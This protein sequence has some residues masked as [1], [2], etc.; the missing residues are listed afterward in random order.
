MTAATVPRPRVVGVDLARGFALIGMA[1]THMLAVQSPD[2]GRLTLVGWVAAGRASALFAV[3]AGVSLALVTGG[4]R[5][6]SGGARARARLSIAF[7]AVLIGLFGLW[8][9][10][11]GTPIAVILAYYALLF[12]LA[13]PFL[14]LRWQT[15]VG[16]AVGWAVLAPWLSHAWRAQLPPGPNDQVSVES[17]ADPVAALR[18]L[19]VIGYYPALV[20]M[21][22]LLAGLA[23]GRL[24]LRSRVVAWWLVG[25]GVGLA[26][27]AWMTS[28]WLLAAGVVDRLRPP[29]AAGTY[30][31]LDLQTEELHG[32]TPP[33]DLAW[34]GIAAPHSGTPFDLIGT[35]SSALAVLGGSLLI[36]RAEWIRTLTRPVA[37]AGTMTL[38]LYLVHGYVLAQDWVAWGTLWYWL[39][40]VASALTFATV[41]LLFFRRGPLES[42][43]HAS[44]INV[45]LLVVPPA[46]AAMPGGSVVPGA[47]AEPRTVEEKRP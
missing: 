44:S 18:E 46:R 13:L 14:G 6:T 17:L 47:T 15:L 30:G 7:R 22:Y 26:V 32:T 4:T 33:G 45:G 37:A 42:L 10:G 8:L 40:H 16:L 36:C 25:V 3:L 24:D 31:W 21:T 9:A 5:P 28:S 12:L 38:T 11:T 35:T 43:V 41:W 19:F 29:G 20:W 2:T 34:L 23:V 1:A 27:L 39:L